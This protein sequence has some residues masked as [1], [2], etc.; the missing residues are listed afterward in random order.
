MVYGVGNPSPSYGQ[1]QKCDGIKPVN[2]IQPPLI[3]GY[4]MTIQM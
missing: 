4:P 2:E 3:I 1:A